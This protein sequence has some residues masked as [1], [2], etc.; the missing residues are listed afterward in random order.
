VAREEVLILFSFLSIFWL[1]HRIF[2]SLVVSF[3]FSVG[4]EMN[5][6][7][8]VCTHFSAGPAALFPFQGVWFGSVVLARSLV[9][10]RGNVDDFDGHCGRVFFS[11]PH[12]DRSMR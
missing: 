1:F 4:E 3:L 6:F 9:L 2:V 8:S 10:G 7:V 12:M 11:K 5:G